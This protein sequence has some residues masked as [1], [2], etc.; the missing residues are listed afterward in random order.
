MK[1]I[2]SIF[3]LKDAPWSSKS[4]EFA[5]DYDKLAKEFEKSSSHIVFAEIDCTQNELEDFEIKNYPTI[6]FVNKIHRNIRFKINNFSL[7]AFLT[8]LK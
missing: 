3:N 8:T 2:L 7:K 1:F 6:K 5:T 4:T